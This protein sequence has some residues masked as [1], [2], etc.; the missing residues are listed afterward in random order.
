M[1]LFG[2][3]P[4]DD[5]PESP[6]MTGNKFW[7]SRPYLG[8][9]RI[10]NDPEE[11][12]EKALAYFDWVE[13]NP[14]VEQKV[15]GTGFKANLD[16]ARPM[17]VG[18]LCIHMGISKRVWTNYEDREEFKV[19]CADVREVMDTY[20]F[21]IAVAG[22]ANANIIARQLGLYDKVMHG[23]DPDNPMPETVTTYQ[24]PDNGR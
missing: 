5:D 12:I 19:A 16:K 22:L 15:F 10:F 14:L 3:P 21:E 8:R 4:S 7:R 18:A 17:S 11:I 6:V 20:N 1:D 2:A 24:L 9:P 13:E 23:S